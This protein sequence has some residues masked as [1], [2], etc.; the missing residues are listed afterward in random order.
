M[1]GCNGGNP[2][3]YISFFASTL[4]GQSV[5]EVNYPYLDRNPLLTCPTGKPIYNSGAYV[6]QGLPDSSCNEDKLKTLVATYG[7]V[8]VAIYASDR[9]FNNYANGVFNGCTDQPANHAVTV[10][11]YG[12]ENGVD[13]WLVKNSWGPSWGLNGFIKIQRGINMCGIGNRCYTATCAPTTGPLSEP[14]IVPP[15]PPIPANLQC[16]VTARFGT[17]SGTY[18]LNVGTSS[19]SKFKVF[20]LLLN[21]H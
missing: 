2:S 14:P 5:H 11:G 9:A 13:Y 12:T 15:P 4:Q 8:A 6:T 16:D 10:V 7:A 21:T 19:G 20:L 18:T 17:I 1:N 3:A